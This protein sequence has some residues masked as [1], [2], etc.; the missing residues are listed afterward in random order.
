MHCYQNNESVSSL[1]LSQVDDLLD[2]LASNSA[3]SDPSIHK[4]Y[5][6]ETRRGRLTL[7]KALF[8]TLSPIEASFLT[9]I[10]LKDLRP[11]LYPLQET[12]YTTSLI[13]YNT[14][15]V[16]MLTEMHAMQAW[17]PTCAMLKAYHTWS[18]IEAAAAYFESPPHHRGPN[19]PRTGTPVEVLALTMTICRY[20][21]NILRYPSLRRAEVI[22]MH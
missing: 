9:H 7:L 3:F 15:S 22:S 19:I 11:I 4:K 8:R 17:D 5:P 6:R 13:S 2:E 12:H 18:T 20:L 1:S 16:R 21:I 10:I 14:T